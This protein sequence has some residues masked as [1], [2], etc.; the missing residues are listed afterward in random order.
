M[1]CCRG[2]CRYC[3]PSRYCGGC[4]YGCCCCARTLVPL[5]ETLSNELLQRRLPYCCPSRCWGAV[6]MAAA[7]MAAVAVLGAGPPAAPAPRT[8]VPSAAPAR[9]SVLSCC[10]GG[11]QYCCPF[12]CCSCCGCTATAKCCCCQVLCLLWLWLPLLLLWTLPVLLPFLLLQLLWLHC[13]CQVL[14]LLLLLL[15]SS[16]VSMAHCLPCPLDGS[17]DG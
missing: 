13:C 5:L 1:S 8:L 14:L 3:C 12:C 16:L 6:P 4:A 9:L 10:C 11:C 17:K 7:L 15:S 2:D